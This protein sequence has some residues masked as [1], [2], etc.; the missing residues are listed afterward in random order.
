MDAE[1]TQHRQR[2][3]NERTSE[4][5]HQQA[6]EML[7]FCC[8][9]AAVRC[10]E[11]TNAVRC[12]QRKADWQVEI[13]LRRK[14][15]QT[16]CA[17]RNQSKGESETGASGRG[18]EKERP[19][20]V[21]G[22]RRRQEDPTKAEAEEPCTRGSRPEVPLP[23]SVCIVLPHGGWAAAMERHKFREED[24]CPDAIKVE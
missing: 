5:D 20:W 4:I 21:L 22:K 23:V 24:S 13:I 10:L 11:D 9:A 2:A 17:G 8:S 12:C 1:R 15:G 3:R 16:E 7:Q 19:D 18:K 14:A 6:D